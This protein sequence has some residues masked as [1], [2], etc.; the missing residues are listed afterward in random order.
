MIF[1]P[2]H[3]EFGNTPKGMKQVLIERGLWTDKL[4]MECKQCNPKATG[5][6]ATRILNL[7]PDFKEQ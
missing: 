7:Q 4:R 3:P 1:P 6:C 5:C 2:N